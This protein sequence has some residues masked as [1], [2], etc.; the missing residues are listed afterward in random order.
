MLTVLIFIS[1]MSFLVVIKVCT[2]LLTF[3]NK[4]EEEEPTTCCQKLKRTL[5]DKVHLVKTFCSLFPFLFTSGVFNIGTISLAIVV[6]HFDAFF[7]L[8]IAFLINLTIFLLV[9][10]LLRIACV[11]KYLNQEEVSP[12]EK[13]PFLISVL[14][15][16]TNLFILSCSLEKS[17]VQKE[18]SLLFVQVARVVTNTILLLYLFSVHGLQSQFPLVAIISTLL[19]IVGTVYFLLIWKSSL[20]RKV[21]AN[22]LQEE[23]RERIETQVSRGQVE[24]SNDSAQ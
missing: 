4:E 15:S 19:I 22:P 11:R 23:L 9:P 13:V 3:H 16:W 21:K 8:G 17:R 7:F 24:N 1:Q 6:L 18:T 12:G 10:C 20:L 14:L 2:E 5:M